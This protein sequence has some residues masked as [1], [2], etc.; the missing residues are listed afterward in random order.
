MN[1]NFWFF[2]FWPLSRYEAI[3]LPW[4]V[5]FK[6]SFEETEPSTINHEMVHLEQIE[7]LGMIKFYFLYLKEYFMNLI[8]YRNHTKAYENISFE[9][10]AYA[11]EAGPL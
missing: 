8:K 6:H 2:K 4:G 5:Y 3:T 7:K 11:R 1:F 9:I 10:E